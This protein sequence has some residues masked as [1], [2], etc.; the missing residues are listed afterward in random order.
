[1][2]YLQQVRGESALTTGLQLLPM[3]VAAVAAAVAGS[4]LVTRIGT[5]PVQ[6]AGTLFSV[7]GLALLA[8][9]GGD[10]SYA[11][12]LLPGF[13]LVGI[14]VIGVGVPGQIAAVAEVP[15]R[16]AGAASGVINAG[17][18]IGGALGLA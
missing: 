11:R 1:A 15:R 10:P 18:Q 14:G 6:V 2:F 8:Q 3:G 9:V 12:D 17:Y 7:A 5:R 16:H 4:H 13:I